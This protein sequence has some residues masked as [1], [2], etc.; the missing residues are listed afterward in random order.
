MAC[1]RTCAHDDTISKTTE[2]ANGWAFRFWYPKLLRPLC[3]CK[4]IVLHSV[5]CFV[6]TLRVVGSTL[7]LS[8]NANTEDGRNESTI[9]YTLHN[10]DDFHFTLCWA[11]TPFTTGNAR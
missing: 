5:F 6:R 3:K 7:Q 4:T 11:L 10:D 2:Q 8:G 9:A 1:S